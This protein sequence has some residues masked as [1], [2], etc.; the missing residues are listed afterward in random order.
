[1]TETDERIIQ[2]IIGYCKKNQFYPSYE[3]I[4]KGIGKTKATVHTHMRRLEGEGVIIRKVDCSPQYR[5][6]NMEFILKSELPELQQDNQMNI[7]K[8]GGMG[9]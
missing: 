2:F 1:M 8:L 6:I 5:L 4:A 3:E 9:K 7:N